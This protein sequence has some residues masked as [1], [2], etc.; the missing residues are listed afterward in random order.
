[1]GQR[2]CEGEHMAEAVRSKLKSV[3]DVLLHQQWFVERPGEI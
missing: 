2:R 1:M 3:N